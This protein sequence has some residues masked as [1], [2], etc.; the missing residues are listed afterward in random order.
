MDDVLLYVT[1]VAPYERGGAAGSLRLAGVHRALQQSSTALAE[2][3][4]V[5]GLG[6]AH[7]SDVRHL[8][9]DALNSCRVLAL[10]TIGE[11]P[12]SE[13][14]K[15]QILEQVRAGRTHVLG[16]PLCDRLV[17]R[18][19]GFRSP[20]RSSLRRTPV[21]PGADDR[22]HR[23]RPS[24]DSAPAGSLVAKR[25][26]LPFSEP[27]ARRARAV[28]TTAGRTRH[29]QARCPCA[30]GRVPARLEPLGGRRS[31][32]LHL[33]RPLPR[34][35]RE[36]HLSAPPLRGPQLAPRPGLTTAISWRWPDRRVGFPARTAP[37]PSLP[38]A[39]QNLYRLAHSGRE[40]GH[41]HRED[42]L[43]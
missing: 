7:S 34:V 26:D 1:Q 33:A 25:R 27:P 41:A 23:R 38:V 18:L 9:D 21:D 20:C 4:D 6:F 28:A 35:L 14:Q 37:R 3:A 39:A 16:D 43:G 8:S 30:R 24:G 31:C 2:M 36:R 22:G 17:P 11:T 40:R 13:P 19:G 15:R 32:L 29:E 12:W 42:G 10:Y 5:A